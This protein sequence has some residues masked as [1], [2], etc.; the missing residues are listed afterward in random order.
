M[1][2][3]QTATINGSTSYTVTETINGIVTSRVYDLGETIVYTAIEGSF[4]FTQLV[5]ENYPNIAISSNPS[6]QYYNSIIFGATTPTTAFTAAVGVC[7]SSGSA[8]GGTSA[9]A[10]NQVT[11]NASLAS[12]D[13]KVPP[14][15]QALITAS[16]PVVL[17]ISQITALTPPTNTGYALDTSVNSLLKPAST[18][19]A[20]TTIGAIAGALPTGGNTIG[21]VN[22]TIGTAAFTKVTDGTNTAVVKGSSIAAVAADS[23]LVVTVSPN[24]NQ[25]TATNQATTNASLSS[26][27]VDIAAIK[28]NTAK[29][30]QFS[31]QLAEDT[32]GTVFLIKTDTIAG[33]SVNINVATGLA[34]TPVGAIELTDPFVSALQL[35][36]NEFEAITTNAGNWVIGDILTRLLIVNTN[37]N[38]V[39]ATIWQSATGSTLAVVP[40]VGTDVIDG[41]K[42]KIV[43]LRSIDT[44]TPSVGQASIALSSPVVLPAAQITTLTPPP[45]ITGFALD[46][47]V[48]TLLKPA[49]TLAA[50]TTL[51]TITNPLPVGTNTIGNVNQT[52]GAAGFSKITDGTNTSAVKPASIAAIATD[53]ALVVTISPNGNQATATN[54]TTTNA[55]LSSIA[56]NTP[57]LGQALAAASTPVVLPVA[58][59]IALTPPTNTGYALD[60]SV[61]SL[62][63][64][65]STLAAVT[66][67][68]TIT[69]PLPTGTN[70]I[71]NVNQLITTAGF[72]KITDGTNTGAV[73]AASTAPVAVDPALVV[74]L[75]PN[76]NQATSTNQTTTNASLAS[77]VTN[78]TGASTAANQTTGNTSL[79]SID[80]KTPTLGQKLAVGSV[81]VVIASDNIV[82][83]RTD[84]TTHGTTDRVAADNVQINGAA[85]TT[86]LG[87][88]TPGSQR[89][90]VAN[91]SRIIPWDGTT[92][93]TV[94]PASINTLATDTAEVVACRPLI[95]TQ[96]GQINPTADTALVTGGRIRSLL[97]TNTSGATVFLGV[98][99]SA[100]ALTGASVVNTGYVIRVPAGSTLDKGIADFSVNGRLFGATV[101]IG[102]SST[103]ATFTA[104]TAPILALCSLN[105]EIN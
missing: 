103:F 48:N 23:A 92:P 97:F 46:T 50:V 40:V 76:G 28:I 33:T 20:I 104:L 101:R 9:T 85:I 15:G 38:T 2:F 14:L 13:A 35:E 83:V 90:A 70:T 82:T 11:G 17:P 39:T 77:I 84:Q 81:P 6:S 78:T 75:S 64:P 105:L 36:P 61:N 63:K 67:L 34:Y 44:K 45:A 32:P 8:G 100:V 73:K 31:F 1:S 96:V 58:Q 79:A 51:G 68:G 54:Q 3:Q 62:L 65:A 4:Q 42:Q 29:I 27:S 74:V 24:G 30:S 89:I 55:S 26:M 21:N 102:L 86:G 43:L 66:T 72:S 99:V 59:I 10:P 7:G 91:D 60:T 16:T 5:T 87:A 41:D 12:I 25:A 22:Q 56:T 49:S 71:G 47:S 19:A 88:A 93:I 53:P 94:K 69:N 80:V 95:T 37:T 18:L 52:I 98:Y 57:P